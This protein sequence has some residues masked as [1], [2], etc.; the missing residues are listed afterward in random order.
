MN[1]ASIDPIP[2]VD[3]GRAEF[4][5]LRAVIITKED[6]GLYKLGTHYSIL[7]TRNI[8]SPSGEQLMKTAD[9]PRDKE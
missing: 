2:L 6:S 9:E 8:F 1:S 4:P 3:R 5:N 7:N